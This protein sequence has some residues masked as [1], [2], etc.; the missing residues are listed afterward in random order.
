MYAVT[1]LESG[2]AGLATLIVFLT[3][4]NANPFSVTADMSLMRKEWSVMCGFIFPLHPGIRATPE[5]LKVCIET[6][7]CGWGCDNKRRAIKATLF[8]AKDKSISHIT[9]PAPLVWIPIPQAT[10]AGYL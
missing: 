1:C 9:C 6:V 4:L 5:I 10:G 8:S 2:K 7:L 3:S